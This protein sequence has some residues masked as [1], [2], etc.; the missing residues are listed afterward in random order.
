MSHATVE[1]KQKFAGPPRAF[2]EDDLELGMENALALAQA[3]GFM[4]DWIAHRTGRQLN[5]LFDCL[6]REANQS[7]RRK[8][9]ALRPDDAGLRPFVLVEQFAKF[10]SKVAV[11]DLARGLLSQGILDACRVGAED[12]DKVA[13]LF[14]MYHQNWQDLRLVFHL[15]KIHKTGF[16]RMRL[17]KSVRRPRQ[18]L[19]DFLQ[20]DAVRDI[21]VSF[22]KAKGDGRT[23][24]L[25]DVVVHD[26]RHLVFIRR[27]ERPDHILHAGQVVHGYRPEWIIL[28][29]TEDAKHVNISSVSV[30]VP[31]EIANRLASGYFHAT[32][33]YEN[34]CQITY[35]KQLERFLKTLQTKD[36]GDLV[37]VEIVVTNSP[38]DG[39]PKLKISDA[40]SKPIGRALA[41]F[42]RAIG[43]LLAHVDHIDSVKVRYRKKRISLIFEPLDGSNGEYVVRYSDHRLNAGERRRFEELIRSSHGIEILSTEKRFKQ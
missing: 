41:H 15:D 23:S 29:F 7:A 1:K 35:T 26:G 11:T 25:K 21:L 39:A 16:A 3:A 6:G 2:W 28:D 18:A 40:D 27:A 37:L 30:S 5:V 36:D 10:K 14:A 34:E 33:E 19:K 32:C 8:K 42:E 13:L 38:L 24:E 9:Q 12:F 22:D 31:L 4:E 20:P 17:G 43:K